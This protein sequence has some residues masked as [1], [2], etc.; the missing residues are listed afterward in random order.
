VL[1]FTPPLADESPFTNTETVAFAGD[2]EEV[3]MSKILS[4]KVLITVAC[5]VAISVTP[6]TAGASNSSSDRTT[7]AGCLTRATS[8]AATGK[9][10]APTYVTTFVITNTGS[11]TSRLIATS[12][13]TGTRNSDSAAYRLD[14]DYNQL[15]P[16]LGHIIEVVGVVQEQKNDD[17]ASAVGSP[18]SFLDLPK[19]RV[20]SV[21]VLSS[22]CTQ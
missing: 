20:E 15:Y 10:G 11:G 3:N 4:F 16:H 18:R 21:K 5:L 2:V 22:I 8:H 6:Q 13:T 7:V 14:A 9:A 1:R 19:L 12:G 17:I